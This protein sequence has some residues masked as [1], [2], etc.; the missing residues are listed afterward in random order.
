MSREIV[1]HKLIINLDNNGDFKTGL[2]QYRI[3]SGGA[4]N[5]KFFTMTIDNGIQI[6]AINGVLAQAKRH[7]EKGEGIK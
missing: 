2:L 3:R 6:A 7:A 5:N 1:P 4:L